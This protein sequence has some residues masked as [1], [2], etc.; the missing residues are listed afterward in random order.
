MRIRIQGSSGS[1]FRFLARSGFNKSRSETL[2][3]RLLKVPKETAW[4][5][6]FLPFFRKKPN[7]PPST[8]FPGRN[9]FKY[10]TNWIN[11]TDLFLYRESFAPSL[12]PVREELGIYD[13][14]CDHLTP[15]SIGT[16][17]PTQQLS[18]VTLPINIVSKLH[19]YWDGRTFFV[20]W[21]V[22]KTYVISCPIVS[23]SNVK[24][25]RKDPLWITVSGAEFFQN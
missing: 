2:E 18:P 12:I 5:T 8:W 6:R 11:V 22:T 20:F 10:G 7:N 17:V 16:G 9:I 24:I 14:C 13:N 19:F 15:V 21:R 4:G 1:R 23:W 3:L 25:C